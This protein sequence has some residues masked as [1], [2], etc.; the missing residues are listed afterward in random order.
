M[1]VLEAHH[2]VA[3][4]GD[5]VVLDGVSVSVEETELVAVIGPNGAGKSTLLKSIVG[6][7]PPRSG[8]VT[9]H[10]T[11]LTRLTTERIVRM[12]LSYVPQVENVFPSLTV[13]ENLELMLPAQTPRPER[14]RHLEDTLR[15]FPVL[16][17]RLP[18]SASV[19]SGGE[20]QMLALARGLMNRPGLLLLDEPT[21][22]VAPIVVDEILRK[23]EE[24]RGSGVPVLLVEQNARR[25]LAMSDRGYILESGRNALSGPARELLDDPEV[26]RL[27]LGLRTPGSDRA[28]RS[29]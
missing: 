9:Y 7:V 14:Q 11:E 1:A 8:S 15:L 16:T 18:M 6:L 21:A 5:S 4:Y 23:V 22:A 17:S 2:V 26:G 19:L 28:P 29:S 13:R 12:G 25:A 27:Y 20:R 10:G 24:I 3:G